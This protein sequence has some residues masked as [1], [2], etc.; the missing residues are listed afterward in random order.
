MKSIRYRRCFGGYQL[1]DR[2]AHWTGITPL[3]PGGGND[4]VHITA[5]GLLMISAGYAWDGAT[6]AP[7]SKSIMRASLIHDAL[8]QLIRMGILPPS[9]RVIADDILQDVLLEDG[10]YLAHNGAERALARG[11]A[12]FAHGMVRAFAG[13]AILPRN[14]EEILTAP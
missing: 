4:F 11:Y 3:R 5:D 12:S 13:R 7:D 14:D 8:Y 1:I 10:L 2:Y 6:M 9:R